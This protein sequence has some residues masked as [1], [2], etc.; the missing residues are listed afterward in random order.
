MS[1]YLHR[2]AGSASNPGGTIHPVV[3]SIFSPP[4]SDDAP[5]A[6]GF[7]ETAATEIRRPALRA[8]DIASAVEQATITSTKPAAS[9]PEPPQ[10]VRTRQMQAA[11]E[12]HPLTTRGITSDSET[13]EGVPRTRTT[14]TTSTSEASMTGRTRFEEPAVLAA[15][16]SQPRLLPELPPSANASRI[17]SADAVSSAP[18]LRTHEKSDASP[19]ARGQTTAS[20]SDEIQIHIGRI[21]VTA[22]APAPI[23]VAPAKPQRRAPSLEEYLR[24]R[25]GRAS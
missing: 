23:Q 9:A 10:I 18:S 21:E 1:G 16:T 13:S 4:R 15:Q 19:S 11:P 12:S 24:S 22:T 20:D 14:A 2:L 25:D 7:E 3:G 5:E 17:R 6:E 8:T